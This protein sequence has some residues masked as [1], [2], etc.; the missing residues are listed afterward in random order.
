MTT[1]E[2]TL[3]QI[4]QEIA[5]WQQLEDDVEALIDELYSERHRHPDVAAA[6]EALR[7]SGPDKDLATYA[8]RIIMPSVHEAITR[9][10]I[11]E[12]LL[13]KGTGS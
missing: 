3:A 1:T 10:T 9:P 11:L 13:A 7:I 5:D 8:L 2:R 4:D 12:R 6:R